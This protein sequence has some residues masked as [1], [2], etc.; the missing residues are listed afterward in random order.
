MKRSNKKP[1]KSGTPTVV[2]IM[3]AVGAAAVLAG[4]IYFAYNALNQPVETQQP[5]PEAADLPA[6]P[7][8]QLPGGDALPRRSD[9]EMQLPEGSALPE[10]EGGEAPDMPE[11]PPLPEREQE[12]QEPEPPQQQSP[13]GEVLWAASVHPFKSNMPLVQPQAGY[14]F[15][16]AL[17]RVSNRSTE[18]VHVDHHATSI[19]YGGR[20][21]R[22]YVWASG[23]DAM[24]QRRFLS[25]VDLA[26]GTATEGYVAF[27]LPQGARD[28]VP[29]LNL[30]GLPTTIEVR[31]VSMDNLPPV[32]GA[33]PTVPAQ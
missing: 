33:E 13:S 6:I 15:V 8:P 21:Y 22:P 18:T 14:M 32:R 28:V 23:M 4:V 19:T 11:G 12:P 29:N 26:P 20:T 2:W 17:Y 16:T 30:Q 1:R 24:Q 25:P 31:R 9:E 10:G 5:L 3:V 7:R 27:Q